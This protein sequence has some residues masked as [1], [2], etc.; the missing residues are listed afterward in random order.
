MHEA[1][2]QQSG[3]RAAAGL[4]GWVVLIA[5]VAISAHWGAQVRRWTWEVTENIHYVPDMQNAYNWGSRAANDGYLE[6][7]EN[8][9]AEN[10]DRKYGLDY[11]PLRLGLMTAWVKWTREHFPE[12]TT[13]TREY[14]FN[15]PLLLFNMT[16]EALA[17]VLAGMLVWLW[18]RRAHERPSDAL[19]LQGRRWAPDREVWLGLIAAALVWFNP[20]MIISAH[21]RPTWDVWV[22]PFY[23]AA[24][25]LGCTNWWFMAG[26]ALAVGSMFKG[27][28][29][30][31]LATLVLWP[32]FAGRWTGAVRLVCGFA[33]GLAAIALPWLVTYRKPID[34]SFERVAD[35]W[36]IA[37]LLMLM[38]IPMALMAVR[39]LWGTMPRHLAA[40]V[41]LLAVTL[42]SLPFLA[43][44]SVIWIVGGL[45]AGGVLVA[46][47]WIFRERV[48]PW[49]PIT[50]AAIGALLCIRLFHGNAGW[51][52][53][54]IRYGADKMPELEIGGAMSMAGI[55]QNVYRWKSE[56]IVFTLPEG[57]LLG[58][59]GQMAVT[60]KMLLSALFGAT[61]V[62]SAVAMAMHDRRRDARFLAVV[63]TPWVCYFAIAPLMHERYLLW[64]AAA[65]A[66]C[67]GTSWGLTLLGVMLSLLSWC[68]SMQ[69]MLWS[70][71]RLGGE[72]W[73]GL[74]RDLAGWLRPMYPHAG[75]AALLAACVFLYVSFTRT[76]PRPAVAEEHAD[77]TPL[78]A[79]PVDADSES[80][81]EPAPADTSDDDSAPAVAAAP[82]LN[83]DP[84]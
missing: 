64:G 12:Q 21:G 55:L 56:S 5:V 40:S 35:G 27:Q 60:M 51:W 7:Y 83:S 2:H 1:E 47:A 41:L 31:V 67:V 57:W 44:Q 3:W 63:A 18:V 9:I 69:Q 29:M 28:Q 61:L 36:A 84:A 77:P 66:V 59:G 20:A 24:V 71:G 32:I 38:A 73:P 22:V 39:R 13:W 8:V 46:V 70:R 17:A 81:T 34:D 76:R 4:L 68:M 74:E 43:T 58:I 78:P 26:I 52:E 23:L 6:V 45:A 49:L 75:W 10:P 48:L 30:L 37:W 14:A 33:T 54:P 82:V 11:V 42:V 15:R 25:L 72:W 65:A 80:P 19:P 16:L 79:L 62:L 50:A 53:V